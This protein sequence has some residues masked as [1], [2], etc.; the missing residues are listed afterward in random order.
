MFWPLYWLLVTVLTI[1]LIRETLIIIGLSIKLCFQLAW[2]CIL[3]CFA[4]LLVTI[5]GVQKLMQLRK[6]KVEKLPPEWP[7]PWTR[8]VNNLDSQCGRR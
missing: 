8:T 6:P 2:L 1:L 4:A 3:V 7:D 5:K